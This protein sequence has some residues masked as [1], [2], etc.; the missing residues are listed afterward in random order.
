[1]EL[2]R[3][4]GLRIFTWS[5]IIIWTLFAAFPIYWTIVTSFKSPGDVGAAKPTFIP[6]VDFD[7][8]IESFQGIFGRGSDFYDVDTMGDVTELMTHSFVAAAGSALLAVILGTGAAYALARFRFQKWR[9]KDIAFWIISQRMFPPI[10][11]VVPFFILFDRIDRAG[12]GWIGLDTLP[13]LILVYTGANLPIVVWLLRDYFRDLP[14]ELEEASLVDGSTRFGAFFKIA[15]PLI[16]P[17]LVI[18]FLFAFVFA[19][20]EFFFAFTLTFDNAK[21]L[22]VQLASNVTT[23]G[24]RYWDICAQALIVMIPPLIIALLTGRYIIRGLTLGA[25]KR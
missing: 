12:F 2:T 11:L 14:A 21:T 4:R 6:W 7:P 8:T 16:L 23:T 10:A 20:N 18:A 5:V 3:S 9:N 1:M 17:G 19:W 24:P 15:L 13:A 22:P 25:V